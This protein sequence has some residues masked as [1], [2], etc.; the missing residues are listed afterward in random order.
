MLMVSG[1]RAR[2]RGLSRLMEAVSVHNNVAVAKQIDAGADVNERRNTNPSTALLWAVFARNAEAVQMLLDAGADPNAC[3]FSGRSVLQHAIVSMGA[4]RR[5]IINLLLAAGADVACRDDNNGTALTTAA[6]LG[7]VA[8]MELLIDMHAPVDTAVLAILVRAGGRFDTV[9]VGLRSV[10]NGVDASGRTALMHAVTLCS[11]TAH[12]LLD[13]NADPRVADIGGHTALTLAATSDRGDWLLLQL[14]RAGAD[15]EH[16]NMFGFTA[17]GI[18]AGSNLVQ[19][20]AILRACGATM[21]AAEGMAK[22]VAESI[23]LLAQHS[24]HEAA[25]L[26]GIPSYVTALLDNWGGS[27]HDGVEAALTGA[28]PSALSFACRVGLPWRL[29]S[30][31]LC[32]RRRRQAVRALLLCMRRLARPLP[33]EMVER[34]MQLT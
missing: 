15:V 25:L 19:N 30:H 18:A 23:G 17:A 34:V 27:T 10:V 16:R 21:P 4:A 22:P 6:L 5:H 32:S 9:P 31:R 3:R 29:K 20:L 8:T 11:L 14:V 24:P 7:D 2:Q 1:N 28:R 12:A 26:V 33:F 13:A